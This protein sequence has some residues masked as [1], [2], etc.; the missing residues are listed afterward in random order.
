MNKLCKGMFLVLVIG[1][2][3]ISLVRIVKVVKAE[4]EEMI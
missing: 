4:S 1:L 2:F 3:I